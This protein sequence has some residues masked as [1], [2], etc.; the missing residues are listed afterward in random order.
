MLRVAGGEGKKTTSAGHGGGGFLGATECAGGRQQTS[1]GRGREEAGQRGKERIV[2]TC[3][4]T[5]FLPLKKAA[6]QGQDW[7]LNNLG[8]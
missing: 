5:L 8:Y 1:E 2:I 3:W 4:S 6:A 7:L